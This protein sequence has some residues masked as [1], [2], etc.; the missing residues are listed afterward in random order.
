MYPDTIIRQKLTERV[1]RQLPDQAADDDLVRRLILLAVADEYSGTKLSICQKKQIAENIFN[2]M[3]G[4]DVLQPLMADSEITEIMVN[5]PDRIF[6]E[7]HGRLYQ[8]DLSFESEN[9][10]TW[11][12]TH[13]FGRENRQIHEKTPLADMRLPDGSR[14]HAALPPASPDGAAVTIR[15]FTGMQM[16]M[17][18]LLDSGFISHDAASFLIKAVTDR[19]TIFL[20]G[21]TGSGKTTFLNILGQYIPVRERIVTVEDTAEISLPQ[22]LNRVRLEAR[23]PSPD[24]TGEINIGQLIRESLRMRPDR[25]IVGEVRG[26]EA[27]EMLQAMNTGHPG[28]LCTGHGN[29]CLDML[30]RLALMVLMAVNLPLDAVYG[31]IASAI[32]YMVHLRRQTDGRRE[33]QEISSV[34][35]CDGSFHLQRIFSRS[36]GILQYAEN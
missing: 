36:E 26:S 8:S 2:S 15:K 35:C 24:G 27:Y 6:Y 7:K 31:L 3:R 25:L 34:A 20:S 23:P 17:E 28:S 1:L 29:S 18:S 32:D 13:L 4:F 19:K 14:I 21:G 22:S 11:L 10:L 12:I 16:N 9:H 33:I 5:S 30:K